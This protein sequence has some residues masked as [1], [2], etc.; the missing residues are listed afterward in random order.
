[1]NNRSILLLSLLFLLPLSAIAQ[2]D[3]IVVDPV[4]TTLSVGEK[5]VFKATGYDS[6]DNPVKINNPN[7]KYTGDIG[8]IEV[9]PDDK[10]Q[11]T[12]T[13]EK[14]GETYIECY[15]GEPAHGKPHGSVDIAVIKKHELS[16][17]E[18]SPKK[19][20]VDLF[21]P[22]TFTAK[23]YDIYGNEIP[24]Y[25]NWSCK[26]GVID[27]YG[28]LIPTENG[29][30][31][32]VAKVP[33]IKGYA[34]AIIEPLMLELNLIKTTPSNA[35]MNVGDTQTF[36]AQGFDKDGN[37][38]SIDP[39]WSATGGEIDVD[40]KYTATESGDH[41]ITASFDGITAKGISNIKV[42]ATPQISRIEVTPSNATM[43]V[44]DTQT[45]QAQGF[46]EDGNQVTI[47]PQWSA[48]GGEIDPS[49]LFTGTQ[50]G[51]Y[52]IVCSIT[53]SPV[54]GKA[55]VNVTDH[56][57]LDRIEV[58]P[59]NA[60]MNVGDT[61][62]FQAQGFD[63]D[64]NQIAIVP[65]WSA[66]GGEIDDK[67]NYEATTVGQ[68]EVKVNVKN[69]SLIGF[70]RVQI[71][72]DLT[73]LTISPARVILIPD[74]KQQFNSQGYDRNGK[75][76]PIKPIWSATGGAISPNGLYTAKKNGVYAIIVTDIS[77]GK[78]GYASANVGDHKLSSITISPSEA[79]MK[80]GETK[81]FT[82]SGSDADG[83][84]VT[85]GPF[86]SVDGA[87]I[88]QSG[89]FTPE[90]K[91]TYLIQ[92]RLNVEEI[93]QIKGNKIFEEVIG[94]AEVIVEE[95]SSVFDLKSEE[96]IKIFPNPADEIIKFSIRESR[97]QY[98]E[99]RILNSIGETVY[100]EQ[101]DNSPVI[102][103]NISNLQSGVYFVV[104]GDQAGAFIKR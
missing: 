81:I 17:I 97:A 18:I 3:R 11:C 21:K 74:Q 71:K 34:Y 46:D 22:Q 25:P 94:E 67:G 78:K 8:K 64:G 98:S 20:K 45:F 103:L 56:S 93:D 29:F 47:E 19:V 14:T 15:D 66:T 42:N 7:W 33:G 90:Q 87:N 79:T 52:E 83:N 80:V 75:P 16:H 39:V 99:I 40:G 57:T 36:Q 28:K 1:M 89:E 9:D 59:S 60:T 70:A 2:I 88:S 49:G 77:T 44:G 61:Q 31:K 96:S 4:T 58:T 54:K 76:V 84:P 35:T 86:W 12:F 48:T 50:V 24:I 10:T 53:D 43:N 85:I 6:N 32:V 51:T 63:K 41:Q 104:I 73:K 92:A 55:T 82:A 13:P 68:F 100:R 102:Q 37:Q 91:G 5:Q 101:L 72:S 30:Y 95:S 26:G 38:I 62:T 23:G 69:N 27:P 65:Q